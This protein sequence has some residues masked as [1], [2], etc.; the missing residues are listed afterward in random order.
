MISKTSRALAAAMTMTVV[1]GAAACGDDDDAPTGEAAADEAAASEATSDTTAATEEAEGAGGP[2]DVVDTGAVEAALGDAIG[3][4]EGGTTMVTENDLSWTAE[5]CEWEAESGVEL[6]LRMVAV[7]A[8]P[9]ECPPLSSPVYEISE[10][11][12]LGDAAWFELDELQGEGAVRVCT[13]GGMA[14]ARLES[15]DTPLDEATVQA[16]AVALVGPAIPAL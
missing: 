10:L 15:G 16:T 6:E 3:D 4:G 5:A 8:L 1:L 14:E 11:P 12:D 9:G 13:A 7:D 2:C